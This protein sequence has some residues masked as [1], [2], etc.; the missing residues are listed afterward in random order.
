MV[1]S[2]RLDLDHFAP[3]EA[4]YAFHATAS[5][6]SDQA[7]LEERF[8]ELQFRNQSLP[9]TTIAGFVLTN[10]DE[11]GK[12]VDIDLIARDAAK[13]F[14]FIAID[15]TFKATSFPVDFDKLY[16]SDE[17][18]HVDEEDELRTL[19]LRPRT[20]TVVHKFSVQHPPR[21]VWFISL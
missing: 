7:A 13:S 3:S 8:E 15:P 14:T 9:G 19:L 10:L 16:R 5:G 12:A 18:F 2:F 4:A 11:G 21:Y 1:P 17:L 6:H 20:P